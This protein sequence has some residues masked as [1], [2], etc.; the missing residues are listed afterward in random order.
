MVYEFLEDESADD[1]FQLNDD[2][3]DPDWRATP[4][5]KQKYRKRVM[6]Q[7]TDFNVSIHICF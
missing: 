6:S 1:S 4:L 2:I 7:M 5:Y 3:K